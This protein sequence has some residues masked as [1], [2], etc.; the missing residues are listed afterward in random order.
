MRRADVPQM[1]SEEKLPMLRWG[2]LLG[3]LAMGLSIVAALL[4]SPKPAQ[5]D[6]ISQGG[7]TVQLTGSTVLLFI[8]QA[9][10]TFTCDGLGA[11]NRVTEL[12]LTSDNDDDNTPTDDDKAFLAVDQLDYI[13]LP[14]DPGGDLQPRSST[15]DANP[16]TNPT[17]STSGTFTILTQDACGDQDGVPLTF[18]VVLT[19]GGLNPETVEI[20][21][22]E[23]QCDE[24]TT[25]GTGTTT[26][27]TGTT[28]TGTTGTGTTTT[29]TG[30]TGTT[31]TGPGTT[32]GN[33][34][35]AGQDNGSFPSG[36]VQSG[37][38]GTA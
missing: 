29:G 10:F 1:T 26:T 27:G 23:I 15:C 19:G 8:D 18:D 34:R 37:A 12:V 30:T 9:E 14:G 16:V 32:N 20:N 22:L 35:C 7:C 13:C 3:L 24:G 5:G 2:F 17:G 21:D 4:I 36:G 33:C 6:P 25:T 28:G 31:T 11:N 38:G